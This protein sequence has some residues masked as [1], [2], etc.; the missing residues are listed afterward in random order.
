MDAR[1]AGEL[2]TQWAETLATQDKVAQQLGRA[3]TRAMNAT[4]AGGRFTVEAVPD[5]ACMW[6]EL[7]ITHQGAWHR[8]PQTYVVNDETLAENTA[9]V[10]AFHSWTKA[11]GDRLEIVFRPEPAAGSLDRPNGFLEAA[12]RRAE[13]R[14]R[15]EHALEELASLGVTRQQREEVDIEGAIASIRKALGQ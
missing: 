15:V 11:V 12:K 4:W 10:M 13:H 1:A 2:V 14:R 7:R 9:S 6:Y 5:A 3:L 8:Q